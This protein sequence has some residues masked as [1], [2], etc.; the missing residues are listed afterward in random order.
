MNF[1][2]NSLDQLAA[3][4]ASDFSVNPNTVSRFSHGT[5][6]VYR[7]GAD[8]VLKLYHPEHSSVAEIEREKACLSCMSDK[9]AGVT[10]ELIDAASV[11]GIEFILMSHIE[12]ED[13]VDVW[14]EVSFENRV[15][16]FNRLGEMIAN[17]HS[18]ETQQFSEYCDDWASILNAQLNNCERNLRQFGLREKWVKQ[19]L[20]WVNSIDWSREQLATQVILHTEIMRD[21]LKVVKKNNEWSLSGI[22]DFGDAMVGPKEYDFVAL[23][24]LATGGDQRLLQ[25]F[26]NGYGYNPDLQYKRRLMAYLLIHK[27]CNIEWFLNYVPVRAELNTLEDLADTWYGVFG[28]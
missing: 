1:D 12:G 9:L 15:A 13:L 17:I 24:C 6:A 7:L 2:N 19:A 16:L 4:I 25:A 5:A 10:P 18:I 26:Y 3:T 23:G 8:K 27:Y 22:F 14:D 21:H 28:K 20:P 11:D